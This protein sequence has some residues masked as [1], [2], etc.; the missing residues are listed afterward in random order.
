MLPN[1]EGGVWEQIAS[2]TNVRWSG[3]ISHVWSIYQKFRERCLAT[4]DLKLGRS[5]VTIMMLP[6]VDRVGNEVN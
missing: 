1:V 6:A 5:L 4:G 3:L 2:C